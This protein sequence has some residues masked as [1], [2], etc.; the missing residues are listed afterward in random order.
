MRINLHPTFKRFTQGRTLI[1][2]PDAQVEHMLTLLTQKEPGLFSCLMDQD[3]QVKPYVNIYINGQN[4][5]Q[6]DREKHLT[7][8]DEI[9]IITSLVGG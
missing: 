4:I 9:D 3:G 6:I 2:L 1:N 5:N 8:E 7:N